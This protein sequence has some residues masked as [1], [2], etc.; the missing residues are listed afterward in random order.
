M[1][2]RIAHVTTNIKSIRVK[3]LAAARCWAVGRK[4]LANNGMIG[5]SLHCPSTRYMVY[6]SMHQGALVFW[7]V[8]F[9]A[10]E[11]SA[12]GVMPVLVLAL[13]AT[14]QQKQHRQDLEPYPGVCDL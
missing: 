3:A 8:L 1:S 10:A 11:A 5:R 9:L 12:V 7:F 6:F 2:C 13:L 14:Q 4:L